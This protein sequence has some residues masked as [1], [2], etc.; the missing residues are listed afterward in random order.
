MRVSGKGAGFVPD[1]V[2]AIGYSKEAHEAVLKLAALDPENVEWQRN[3]TLYHAKLAGSYVQL[4]DYKNAKFLYGV[5]DTQI[6]SGYVLEEQ[7]DRPGALKAY[8]AALAAIEKAVALKPDEVAYTASRDHAEALI[9][10][11]RN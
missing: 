7:G 1:D 10:G 2:T 11:V 5:Y 6:K 4:K 8:E 3:A 9:G